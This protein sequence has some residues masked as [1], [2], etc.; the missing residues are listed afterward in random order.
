M[1]HIHLD[2]SPPTLFVNCFAG[3]YTSQDKP[4][5][6]GEIVIGGHNVSMGYFK[7]QER[8]LEDFFVDE[9]GQRWFCTGDIGE[10]HS[11]GCLQIIGKSPYFIHTPY[12]F[13]T[14]SISHADFLVGFL[15]F[16]FYSFYRQEKGFSKAASRRIRVSGQSGSC[17]EKLST[18]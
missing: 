12:M 10:F 15:N 17:F 1:F 3:G 13:F 7:N 14:F 16:L 8:N 11:D 9:N 18:H 6:R 5:P 4:N 2:L